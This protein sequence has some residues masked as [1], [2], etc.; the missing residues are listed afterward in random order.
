MLLLPDGSF[1]LVLV[2]VALELERLLAIFLKTL[3]QDEGSFELGALHIDANASMWETCPFSSVRL[4]EK[5]QRKEGFFS[6]FLWVEEQC[7]G[8]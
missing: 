6:P 2:K 4:G 8:L 1:Q 5:A 7:K 3:N